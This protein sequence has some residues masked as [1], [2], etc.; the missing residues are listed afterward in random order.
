MTVKLIPHKPD[1]I[2]G[3]EIDG[4]IDAEDIE[5]LIKLIE[6]KIDQNHKLSIYAEVNDWKG[7]SLKAF[8]EDLQFGL[9]H[10]NDFEKEAIV[11]DNKWLEA[12]SAIGNSLF[13]GIE[14]KHFTPDRKDLALK[15]LGVGEQ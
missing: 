7:M 5:R 14:V 3:I 6:P 9:K 15:W 12:L 2:I 4:W 11:S 13:S 8:I 10:I 1:R